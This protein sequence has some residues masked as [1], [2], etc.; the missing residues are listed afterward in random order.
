MTKFAVEVETFKPLRSNTLFG[1]CS[2]LLPELHLTIHDLTIHESND[3]RW[4]GLPG[5][6]WVDRDGNVKRGE[7]GKILYAPVLEFTD[8]ETRDAFAA[9][10]LASLLT[11]FPHVFDE[12]AA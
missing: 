10:V 12:V 11:R 2:V 4:I 8:K 3:K 9:R 7:N 5:K 1:F 6:A